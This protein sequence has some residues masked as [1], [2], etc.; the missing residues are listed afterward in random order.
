MAQLTALASSSPPPKRSLQS[1]LGASSPV[2]AA[3]QT[4]TANTF[5]NLGAGE[6]SATY[7][8]EV[9]GDDGA[10]SASTPSR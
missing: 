10:F 9:Y 1:Y 6:T 8:V 2:G 3:T 7:Y 4:I 5:D